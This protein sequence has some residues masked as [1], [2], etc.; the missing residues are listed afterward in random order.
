MLAA[1]LK[2]ITSTLHTETIKTTEKFSTSKQVTTNRFG[3]TDS[4]EIKAN[5]SLAGQEI[6]P[7]SR[8]PKFHYRDHNSPHVVHML[9]HINPIKHPAP[10]YLTSFLLLSFH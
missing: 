2:E 7:I 1:N 4:V 8:N 10:L 9:C 5:S 3:I 6:P